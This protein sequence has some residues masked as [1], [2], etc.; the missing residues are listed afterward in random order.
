[1]NVCTTLVEQVGEAYYHTAYLIGGSGIIHTQRQ[2]HHCAR[3]A[4]AQLGDTLTT[5]DLA[6]GRLGLIAG[7]DSIYPEV[8]KVLAIAGADVLAIP[9]DAQEQWETQLGLVGRSAENRVCLVAAT[10]PKP[11]GNSLIITQHDDFQIFTNWKTRQFNGTINEP[12]VTRISADATL[13]SAEIHPA[14]ARKKVMS[15]DTDLIQGRAWQLAT[16]LTT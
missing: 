12:I 1:M 10:R 8:A 13:T 11:F 2:L 16:I 15:A 7:D 5:V 14:T 3:H 9:F 4:W 6:W